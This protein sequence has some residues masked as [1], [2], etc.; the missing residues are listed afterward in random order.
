MKSEDVSGSGFA[1]AVDADSGGFEGRFC[2]WSEAEIGGVLGNRPT[3]FKQQYNVTRNGSWEG[4]SILNQSHEINFL[5]KNRRSSFE[6]I[7]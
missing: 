3:P 7:P 5:S 4:H 2:L 1:A 6:S